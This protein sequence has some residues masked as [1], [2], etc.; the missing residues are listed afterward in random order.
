L[1]NSIMGEKEWGVASTTAAVMSSGAL[2]VSATLIRDDAQGG[3]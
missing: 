2:A 3:I 1:V